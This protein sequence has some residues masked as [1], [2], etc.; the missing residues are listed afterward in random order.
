MT[1][2]LYTLPICNTRSI[3]KRNFERTVSPRICCVKRNAVYAAESLVG[4][5]N[6]MW[7]F[8]RDEQGHIATG[9]YLAY[10]GNS[11]FLARGAP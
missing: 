6:T 10:P 11:W 7:S 4:H 3:T 8:G 1:T 2:L 5:R 9:R